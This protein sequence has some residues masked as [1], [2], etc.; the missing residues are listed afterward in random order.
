M[1]H[2]WA[3]VL[4]PKLLGP[5]NKISSS[6]ASMPKPLKASKYSHGR[7]NWLNVNGLSLQPSPTP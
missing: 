5:V 6:I 3:G 7:Y 4:S 1:M 2:I